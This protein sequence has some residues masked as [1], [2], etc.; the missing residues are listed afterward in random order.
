MKVQLIVGK[1]EDNLLHKTYKLI[2][3]LVPK[4]NQKIFLG[5]KDKKKCRF[6]GKDSTQTSFKKKAHIIPEFMGNKLYF[7]NLE[8]DN[9][10]Q[11]F[12]EL[13]DSLFNF[14]GVLNSFSMV[15]GKKGFPKYKGNKEELEIFAKNDNELIIRTV[16]TEKEEVCAIDEKNKRIIIDTNQHSYLPQDA[17]KSLVKIGLIMLKDCQFLKYKEAIEWIRQP[18][19]NN[20][21]HNPFFNVFRKIGEKRRFLKPL[22][23]LMQKRDSQELFNYPH[24][25]LIIFY[26]IIQ[27]QI[28][29]P[30]H[31]D[32]KYLVNEEEIFFV[33]DKDLIPN[34]LDEESSLLSI[35]RINNA[36]FEIKKS[37]EIP[38]ERIHLGS[39]K[40][41]KNGKHEFSFGLKDI[42]KIQNDN[43]KT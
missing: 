7:S 34:G 9:C 28:F 43:F 26:G 30:F 8:C 41:K 33:L 29:L 14:A 39:D 4:N 36:G 1:E 21:E 19:L 25:I 2:N 12:G 23:F 6:C 17:F 20:Q 42:K 32:D 37:Y 5:D 38:F 15:R 13:E 40:K 16:Q 18:N 31:E 11:Y 35:E 24:H 3:S 10:N 22:A 27:Y